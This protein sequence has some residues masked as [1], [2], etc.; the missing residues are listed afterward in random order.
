MTLQTPESFKRR[1]NVEV[2]VLNEVTAIDPSAKSIMVKDLKDGTEYEEN[3]DKLLLATGARPI[4]QNIPG[5]EC[6]RVFSMQTVEDALALE[7][8][9]SAGMPKN[10][11]IAGGGYVGLEM[12]ECLTKR[13]ISVKMVHRSEQLMK[14]LDYDMAC[15]IK[16]Y[17]KKQCVEIMTGTP[18]ESVT[19]SEGK[20]F[21]TAG[22]KSIPTDMVLLALGTVPSTKLAADAG[23]KLGVKNAVLVD[24]H[25][26]TSD[27]DIYAVGD[28][29][30]TKNLV[31]GKDAVI[32]LAGPANRQGRLAAD[33]ICG[34]RTEYNGASGASVFKLFDMTVAAVGLTESE[35]EKRRNPVREC[36]FTV[37]F[38]CRVLSRRVKYDG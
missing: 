37:F 16:S 24:K 28:A 8:F 21:V 12:A 3:Y 5:A 13:G 34:I 26:R 9:I 10:A 27:P 7:A 6:N 15:E 2:R 35:A 25:M 22:G 31:S 20:L 23:L 38:T 36:C 19:E 4:V 17:L 32:P 30:Q 29:V 11:V 1:F 14:T 18:L 33:N